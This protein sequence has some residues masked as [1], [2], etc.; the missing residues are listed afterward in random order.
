VLVPITW[1]DEK[2]H[3]D[4]IHKMGLY[5]EFG[6]RPIC[7]LMWVLLFRESYMVFEPCMVNHI[8]SALFLPRPNSRHIGMV[9]VLDTSRGSLLGLFM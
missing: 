5:G 2:R 1:L 8:G 3:S 4:L 7:G 6:A 9:R